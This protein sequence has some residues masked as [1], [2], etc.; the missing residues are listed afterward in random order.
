[1]GR[2]D[3]TIEIDSK[4]WAKAYPESYRINDPCPYAEFNGLRVDSGL[5]NLIGMQKITLSSKGNGFDQP[6]TG[7]QFRVVFIL[8]YH[9]FLI[10][11]R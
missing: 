10:V 1:M 11:M 3:W 5:P 7:R 8:K 9:T 2:N 6:V 4:Q